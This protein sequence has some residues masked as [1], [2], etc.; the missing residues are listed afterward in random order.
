MAELIGGLTA[1]G[2]NPVLNS[3]IS[4]TNFTDLS[5]MST[6]SIAASM[7]NTSLGSMP[8]YGNGYQYQN[9]GYAS[10]GFFR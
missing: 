10:S 6:S 1:V 3:N 7:L 4:Y 8:G 5:S 2:F 9:Y